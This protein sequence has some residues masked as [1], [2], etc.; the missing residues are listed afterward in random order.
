MKSFILLSL[1]FTTCM[2]QAVMEQIRVDNRA[3]KLVLSEQE[4]RFAGHA[5]RS[6]LAGNAMGYVSWKEIEMLFELNE[7]MIISNEISELAV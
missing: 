4:L 3:Q 1:F 7:S 2:G 5:L 6:V